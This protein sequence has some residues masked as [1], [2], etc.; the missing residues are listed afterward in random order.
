MKVSMIIISITIF[1]LI[2]FGFGTM[3]NIMQENHN[4]T[5]SDLTSYYP[6]EYLRNISDDMGGSV[7]TGETITTSDVPYIDGIITTLKTLAD[8]PSVV[9]SIIETIEEDL[10]VPKFITYGLMTIILTVIGFSVA[11]AIWRFE[12]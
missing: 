3:Y 1:G 10:G 9:G 12:L 11:S 8:L 2:S 5:G 7:K 6:E 4:I